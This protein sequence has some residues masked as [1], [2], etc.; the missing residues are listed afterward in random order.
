VLLAVAFDIHGFAFSQNKGNCRMIRRTKGS[1]W[2]VLMA[3]AAVIGLTQTVSAQGKNDLE[4]MTSTKVVRVG[5]IEAFPYYRKDLASGEWEG[6]IPDLTRLMFGSIG[7][8]VEF[9][10][11]EWGTAAAGLQS[12]KFDLVGGFN[13]TPQRALAVGFSGIVAESKISIVGLT[14]KVKS[15]TTWDAVN[16]P[17][18]KIAAVDGASTTRAAQAFLPK[19]TWTLVKSTDAMILEMESGRA[20]VILSNEPT[21]V[22]F[23]K[24][25]K[26]GELVIPTP[27]RAQPI[28]FGM[29]K[30][31][32]ELQEWVNIALEYYKISGDVTAIWSKYLSTK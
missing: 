20:D 13:A 24:A 11:T 14:D 7:V 30:N 16:T 21:L 3:A 29:R 8:K 31:S 15:L 9:V 23:L 1:A 5:A 18:V 2:R 27:V 25:K 22:L 32:K 28:N 19:A 17:S 26:K 4:R 6:I 12:D 10:P